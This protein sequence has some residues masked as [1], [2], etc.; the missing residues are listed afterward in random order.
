MRGSVTN[1]LIGIATVFAAL[2]AVAQWSPSRNIEIIAPAAAGSAMDN[3]SR[4]LQRVVQE[5]KLTSSTITVAN[6]SGA[7]NA[8]GF[9]YLASHTGDAHYVLVTPLTLI[10]NRITGGNP[11]N[12]EDFTPLAMLANE[13]PGFVVL[14]DSP[15]KSGR[16]LVE[17]LKKD[18]ESV[19]MGLAT[20]LGNASHITVSLVGKSGGADIKRFKIAVFNAGSESVRA[21]MGGHIDLALTGTAALGPHVAAGRLRVIAVASPQRLKGELSQ[22]PTWREQG[23]DVV[24]S[25]WRA[26]I[27]PRGMSAEQIAYWEAL[28]TR[29][30]S[31]EEWMSQLDKTGL[32][33]GFVGSEAT[34]K[35]FAQQDAQLRAT[36]TELGLAK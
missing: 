34:K 13:Y 3:M 10:S 18:P 5:K 9:N 35:M 16:D 26:L 7:G 22:V 11:L 2:P 15:I 30:T 25:N 1:A 6:R 31:Q 27:G 21:V 12:Y 8:V 28:V 24:F 33:P 36:L 4:L 20:G 14:P 17:R 29:I 23:V 32:Q 19:S